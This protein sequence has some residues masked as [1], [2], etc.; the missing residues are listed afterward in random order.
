[1]ISWRM[2]K[3]LIFKKKKR[4]Q[5]RHTA[6]KKIK[7]FSLSYSCQSKH[8]FYYDR[9]LWRYLVSIGNMHG[10][11]GLMN[12]SILPLLCLHGNSLWPRKR[13][14]LGTRYAVLCKTFHTDYTEY[15][16]LKLVGHWWI[17]FNKLGTIVQ[18]IIQHNQLIVNF[19]M[20]L[21][22]LNQNNK[23][24]QQFQNN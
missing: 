7:E 14:N 1:M 21:L 11:G 9:S 4:G 6:W 3:R 16:I 19:E 15:L 13:S 23:Y 20:L 8:L 22:V 2:I 24:S 5:R 17:N 18:F 12:S 10:F